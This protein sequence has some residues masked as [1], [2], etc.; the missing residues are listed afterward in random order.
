MHE[1]IEILTTK[2]V[3]IKD[4]RFDTRLPKDQK[5]LFEKAAVLGGFRNLTDFVI[6]ALQEKA[7]EIISKKDA[8][9]SSEKDNE[10]F[11]DVIF[12]PQAPNDALTKAT[13]KYKEALSL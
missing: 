9:L 11:F 13:I 8:I 3:H 4:A 7:T 2:G 12:N 1:N 5:A 10:I 6:M